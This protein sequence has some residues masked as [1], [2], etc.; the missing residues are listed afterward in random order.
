VAFTYVTLEAGDGYLLATGDVPATRIRATPLV[1]MTNGATV[2]RGQVVIPLL[3]NGTATKPIAATTDPATTPAGN[4]YRFTVEAAGRT[5]RSFTAEVPHDAG[6]TVDL[7]DLVELETVTALAAVTAVDGQA[8]LATYG[9]VT[10]GGTA[11]NAA[12][13]ALPAAGGTIVIPAG[14]WTIDTAVLINKSGIILR[15]VSPGATKLQFDGA[16]IPT[17]IKMADTTQR[18]ITIQDL[19]IESTANGVGTAIDASY[20]VNSQFHRLRIGSSGA[21]PNRGIDFNVVGTYYNTVRDCRIT[22]A[23][24]GSRCIS[25]DNI[26]NSNWVDNC[27]LLGDA[28]TTGVYVNAHANTIA[29]VD[30]ETTMAIGVNV[31]AS[32]HDCTLVSPYLEQVDVGVQ[33]A[34][35]VEAFTCLG[36]I[37]ID[38]DV[39]NIVDNGAKDPAF[40]NTRLQYEPYT[41]MTARSAAFPQS[42]P[43]QTAMA[44]PPDHGLISWSSDPTLQ[45]TSTVLTAGT[46]YLTKVYVRNRV[47]VSNLYW[48]VASAA[49]TA[50]A[51]QNEVGLYD[52]AGTRVVAA[53][54]DGSTTSTGLKT[55]AVTPTVLTPGWYWVAAVFNAATLPGLLRG[56]GGAG[57]TTAA[58]IGLTASTLRYAT[59][60]TAQT[61][62]PATIT[63]A[64]NAATAFAGPWVAIG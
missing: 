10:A 38:S 6:A 20:F 50:T 3:A 32:G 8:N 42:Y 41:S 1:E 15:G 29:R 55:T 30:C 54:V 49:V 63:P 53:N 56:N 44:Q 12:I 51:G 21:A 40:I 33:L 60:A 45:N 64:S 22:V 62:L 58:N 61:T 4:A 2:V 46:V 23:G 36:G 28:N 52:S 14:T 25:F 48:W 35:N 27:R 18:Y 19:N 13:A 47:T 11:L 24:V 26:A 16:T 7:S 9:T 31:G 57:I 5:V 43:I 37:I 17:A 39:N 34:A 59:N